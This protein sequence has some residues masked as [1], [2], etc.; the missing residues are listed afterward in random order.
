MKIMVNNKPLSPEI[1]VRDKENRRLEKRFGKVNL[2]SVL[3]YIEKL[4]KR[5]EI[6]E[7]K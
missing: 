7:N 2:R 1:K 5:I 3:K 4:E 6:L